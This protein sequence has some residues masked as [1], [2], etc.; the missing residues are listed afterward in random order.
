[1]RDDDADRDPR[2]AHDPF[3]P[4]RRE[5]PKDGAVSNPYGPQERGTDAAA[6]GADSSPYEDVPSGRKAGAAD[7]PPQRKPRSGGGENG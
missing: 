4:P 1:M 2:L 5:R 3:D 7:A 6:G